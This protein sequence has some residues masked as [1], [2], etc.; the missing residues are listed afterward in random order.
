MSKKQRIWSVM[1]QRVN[2]RGRQGGGGGGYKLDACVSDMIA[3]KKQVL[4][5][6][7]SRATL[8]AST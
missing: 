3:N 8:P 1:V 4:V 2:E 7:L 5:L 6:V